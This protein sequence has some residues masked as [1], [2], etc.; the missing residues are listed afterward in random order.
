MLENLSFKAKRI[1]IFGGVIAI[2]VSILV[3]FGAISAASGIT[4]LAKTSTGEVKFDVVWAV[5]MLHLTGII[6]ILIGFGAIIIV[7]L[8]VKSV[9]TFIFK[10]GQFGQKSDQLAKNDQ[11]LVKNLCDK[12]R[13]IDQKL[14]KNGHLV[15]KS[16]HLVIFF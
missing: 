13:K 14:T 5:I 4:N 2:L 6:D 1:L 16:G 3:G 11:K 9:A 7:S 12:A 15:K 10:N 8:V